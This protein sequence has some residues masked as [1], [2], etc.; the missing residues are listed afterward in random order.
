MNSDLHFSSATDNWATPIDFFKK[1]DSVFRFNLDVCAAK[2]NAKCGNYFTVE[3][4]GLS[5]DW[6]GTCWMNPPYGRTATGLWMKKAYAESRKKGVIVCALVPAR[7]DTKWFHEYVYEK[8]GDGVLPFFIKGRLKF[9]N[10]KDSAP[11]P[12]MLV[13]FCKSTYM[14]VDYKNRLKQAFR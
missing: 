8:E 3:D 5:K 14:L 12:S 11:F 2:E 7:T 13:V 4:D 9:G 6:Y 1:V 10:S